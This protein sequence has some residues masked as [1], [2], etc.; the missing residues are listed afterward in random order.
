MASRSYTVSSKTGKRGYSDSPASSQ[1]AKKRKSTGKSV[2]SYNDNDDDDC[3]ETT[4]DEL[5]EAR[6]QAVLAGVSESKPKRARKKKGEEQEEKR[7]RRFRVKA[8]A[9]YNER[10]YR[11]R[12]QR[13]FLI[14]RTAGTSEDG[15]PEE[16]FD[17]AGTTGNIYQVR[18]GKV[19]TCSCPDNEKGNQCKHIIY[20]GSIAF[21]I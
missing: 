2:N 5:A 3:R 10:L 6:A 18:I 12:T 19:P 14:D 20:V 9:T 4:Y 16:E 7:L 15:S 1:P 17:I 11:V 13:M 8:P 21:G